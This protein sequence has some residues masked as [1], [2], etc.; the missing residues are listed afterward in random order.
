MAT[1]SAECSS[2][3]FAR[4]GRVPSVKRVTGAENV[5]ALDACGVN[6]RVSAVPTASGA[7]LSGI[8]Q[9]EVRIGVLVTVPNGVM[10]RCV[11]IGGI[12]ER[13]S[14]QGRSLAGCK[15]R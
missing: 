12:E 14:R 8:T 13:S 3:I 5:A 4:D 11:L 9:L 15:S 10:V 1:T 2:D 7:S 6:A